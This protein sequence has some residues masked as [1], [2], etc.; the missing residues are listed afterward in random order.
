MNLHF[1]QT[2]GQGISLKNLQRSAVTIRLR[3]GGESLRPHPKAAT[4]SLKNLLQELH[5]PPWQ[6]RRPY[7]PFTYIYFTNL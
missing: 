1:T 2:L 4:R 6:R 7:S 5:V 3:T